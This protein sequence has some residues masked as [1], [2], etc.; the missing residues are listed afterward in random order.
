VNGTSLHAMILSTKVAT[1]SCL[2]AVVLL[3]LRGIQVFEAA[4]IEAA[5]RL[6]RTRALGMNMNEVMLRLVIVNTL[7]T[8]G[9][10]QAVSIE[11]R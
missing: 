11:C 10:I 9:L 3:I 2:F 4:V 8:S 1:H 5:T 6:S 7:L